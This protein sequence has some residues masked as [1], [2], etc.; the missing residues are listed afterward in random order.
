[1]TSADVLK[2][3]NRFKESGIDIWIV[4][5]WC[6]DALVGKQTREHDD[7]DIAVNQKDNAK[8]RQL[9]LNDGYKEEPRSD[10]SEFMYV[11]TNDTGQSVDVHAFEYDEDGKIICGIEFPFGS[12]TETGFING[13]KVNCVE[14]EFMLRFISWYEPREKDIHD[15]KVLCEKFGFESPPEWTKKEYANGI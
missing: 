2:I 5:G 13:Q 8:L 3:Y 10:S 9:L 4:G 6:V 7:L 11:M 1:M 15:I 14:P 12:L